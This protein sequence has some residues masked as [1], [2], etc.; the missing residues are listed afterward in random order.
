MFR[1][2]RNSVQA[3]LRRVDR[4]PGLGE[5]HGRPLAGLASATVFKA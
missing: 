2:R 3:E 5:D 1:T 4:S